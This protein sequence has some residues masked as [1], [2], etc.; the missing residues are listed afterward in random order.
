MYGKCIMITSRHDGNAIDLWFSRETVPVFALF[1]AAVVG[2]ASAVMITGLPGGSW[3]LRLI[4]KRPAPGVER[5]DA[6]AYIC[7]LSHRRRNA[8]AYVSALTHYGITHMLVYSSSARFRRRDLRPF[9]LRPARSELILT[10]GGTTLS[11][12]SGK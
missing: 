2:M 6:S 1:E 3:R 8:P 9:G 10:I 5:P 7:R 11:Y 4:R 12:G